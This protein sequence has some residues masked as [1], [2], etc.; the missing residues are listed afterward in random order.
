MLDL[1]WVTSGLT[2]YVANLNELNLGENA[3]G[4]GG[5]RALAIARRPGLRTL[6][7]N[8]DGITDVGTNY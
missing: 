3:I 4:D 5:A 2:I 1:A 6:L 8:S 7:L